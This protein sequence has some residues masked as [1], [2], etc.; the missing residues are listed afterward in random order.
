MKI[1]ALNLL[2]ELLRENEDEDENDDLY[3]LTN[4]DHVSSFVDRFAEGMQ[5]NSYFEDELFDILS[6]DELSYTGLSG[7][8]EGKKLIF[9][10]RASGEHLSSFHPGDEYHTGGGS[11]PITADTPTEK[12]LT[13]SLEFEDPTSALWNDS[14]LDEAVHVKTEVDETFGDTKYWERNGWD[15]YVD[16]DD[17]EG[18]EDEQP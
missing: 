9:S 12:T 8:L 15:S 17:E 1:S 5:G 3:D 10:I 11:E 14:F 18:D 7:K 2:V 6:D 16:Y 13:L 4:D